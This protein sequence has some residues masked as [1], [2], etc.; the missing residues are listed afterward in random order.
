MILLVGK[1]SYL[2]KEF[3]QFINAFKLPIST[4]SHD[5]IDN[6]HINHEIKCIVNFA[7]SPKLTKDSYKEQYDIDLKLARYI[8]RTDIH[9][10]MISSRK[11]YQ[12]SVQWDAKEE[13]VATGSGI[14]GKNKLQ[15]ELKLTEVLGGQ[16]TI[17]RP[18][19]VFGYELDPKRGRFGSY[20][21]NQLATA[22][23]I[24]FTVSPFVRRDVVPVSFFCDVLSRV[25]ARGPS[26]IINVG[27]G[28]AIEIGRVA[29]AM[30]EGFGSG[31]ITASSPFIV[32]EFQLNTDRMNKRLGIKCRSEIVL[33]SSRD[34]GRRLK[35][36]LDKIK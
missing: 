31:Q 36:E 28:E 26:G 18:G 20:L 8:Q 21:I 30:I 14:Y 3:V 4:I 2:A 12:E 15:I 33:D 7:F 35:I 6:G 25:I 23:S 5:E 17:L 27:S 19:N 32:D 10:I 16:L 22:G 11:V 34:I 24:H 29:L 1:S 9:Y 13:V